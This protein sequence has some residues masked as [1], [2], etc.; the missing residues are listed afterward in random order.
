MEMNDEVLRGLRIE[1]TLTENDVDNMWALSGRVGLFTDLFPSN[2]PWLTEA[3]EMALMYYTVHSGNKRLSPFY[4]RFVRY[5]SAASVDHDITRLLSLASMDLSMM[6]QR[7][8]YQKWENAYNA[9]LIESYNPLDDFTFNEEKTG[10]DTDTT[11]YDITDGKTGTNTDTVTHD[12]T[13][14]DNGKTGTNETTTRISEMS[15]DVYGFNSSSPVGDTTEN[16]STS[17]TVSGLAD[18]NTT[19]NIQTKT[20]TE[21]KQIGI[22]EQA[23]KTGT[24]TKTFGVNEKINRNGR[25]NACA[26]L[27]QKEL[28]MRAKNIF[29]N[30]IFDDVDSMATLQIY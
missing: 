10:E 16:G 6:L 19:Q 21:S 18:E 26:D 14:E 5:N 2:C 4:N 20:G 11:T 13:T 3:P 25:R 22:N 15:N 30:I 17:E 28:D 8:Y 7:K 29:Y 1:D 9:L 23:T 12:V 24:E 27:I